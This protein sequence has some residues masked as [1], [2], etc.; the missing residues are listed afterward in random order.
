MNKE[1]DTFLNIARPEIREFKEY[2]PGVIPEDC[3]KMH[4][5]EN[6]S[7]VSPKALSAMCDELKRGN[8]YPESRN[9]SLRKKIASIYN[10]NQNQILTGNGLDSIFTMLGRAFLNKGDEVVCG[11]FT[12]SVYA[13]TARI[14]GATPVLVPMTDKFELDVDAHIDA[15]NENTKMVFFCNP[16]NPTGTAASP[17]DIERLI[18][19]S[20]KTALF[21]LDEAYI[22]FSGGKVSTALSL[23]NKYPNLVVCRTFSKIYG[24]AGLRIGWIAANPELLKYIYRVR[25][26]YCVTE[27]AA[28][29]AEAAL[30]DRAFISESLETELKEKERLCE[31]LDSRKIKYI[32]SFANFLLL[33]VGNAEDIY[34][35]LIKRGI[36]VRLLTYQGRKMLRISIGLPEE[37]RLLEKS[38]SEAIPL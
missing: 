22:D 37:N 20:P 27:I 5:N 16:N 38:L 31:F 30:E 7:G 14:M 4:A 12:F 1:Q 24:L 21:I 26:P 33:L 9:S 28:A 17:Y 18:N 35:F 6:N 11:E 36:L 34:S 15:I 19:A 2:N 25:E 23:L 8:R 3:L 13:D 32:P 10:L 29:G